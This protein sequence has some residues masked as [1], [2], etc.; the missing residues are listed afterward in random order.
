MSEI[1]SRM[2]FELCKLAWERFVI[3]AAAVTNGVMR[4]E[5]QNVLWKEE[6]VGEGGGVRSIEMG[7]DWGGFDWG[8]FDWG[9]DWGGICC[10]FFLV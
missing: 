5:S 1:E 2:I 10:F 7:F 4:V 3:E 8:G 9:F 6:S